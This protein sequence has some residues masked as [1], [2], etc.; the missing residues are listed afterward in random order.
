MAGGH[1][2]PVS[3]M[4]PFLLTVKQERQSISSYTYLCIFLELQV[5]GVLR[6]VKHCWNLVVIYQAESPVS[7]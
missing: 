1:S 7:S 4:V 6:E 2:T 5:V 3:R